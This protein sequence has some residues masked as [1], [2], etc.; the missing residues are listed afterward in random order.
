MPSLTSIP[1]PAPANPTGTNSGHYGIAH[2]DLSAVQRRAKK[3]HIRQERIAWGEYLY[4]AAVSHFLCECPERT[5]SQNCPQA[6]VATANVITTPDMV[7]PNEQS[8]N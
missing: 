1:V 5:V 3:N 2:M 4:C 7:V 8:E 6:T